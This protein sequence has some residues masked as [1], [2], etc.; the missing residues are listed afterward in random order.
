MKPYFARNKS[1][2][3]RIVRDSYSNKNTGTSWFDIKRE[4]K[5]RDKY[6]CVECKVP[7]QKGAYHDVHHI[8]PLS[9]GGTTTKPNL[10]TLCDKCHQKRHRHTIGHGT[11]AKKVSRPKPPPD[12]WD[13]ER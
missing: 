5:A 11:T 7:E 1:G 8:K 10:I 3:T 9:R 4:V 13:R 2:V 12:G 6:C